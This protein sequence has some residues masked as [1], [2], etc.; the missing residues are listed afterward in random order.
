MPWV[1]AGWQ[2]P[3]GLLNQTARHPPS[4]QIRHKVSLWPHRPV[5]PVPS[6]YTVTCLADLPAAPL[7]L[8]AAAA[9]T[10]A[11]TSRLQQCQGAAAAPPRRPATPRPTR[12][13]ARVQPPPLPPI[14]GGGCVRLSPRGCLSRGRG[15]AAAA[16]LWRW[17][18]S[19][20]RRRR[21]RPGGSGSSGGGV[22]ARGRCC[23]VAAA[24]ARAAC[25][26]GWGPAR[27]SGG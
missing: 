9:T 11:T 26:V 6:S 24:D 25:Y 2:R 22:I 23:A 4:S 5:P 1:F 3:Q 17:Q 16:T 7:L 10:L 8:A 18:W 21:Q 15:G 13:Q 19:A 27:G 20:Q 12:H 14:P